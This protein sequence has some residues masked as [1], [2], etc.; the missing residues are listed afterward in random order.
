MTKFLG[1]YTGA[2]VFVLS[3]HAS[4]QTITLRA[5]LNGG[6]E[7]PTILNTGAVGTV[8][9]SVDATNREVAV[10]LKVFNLPTPATAGHIHIGSKGIGGPTVLNFPPS[11]VGRTG[12]FTMVF[13]LGDT[14][15]VFTARPAIG[16]NSIEDAIQAIVGGNAYVNVHSIQNSGGEIRGQLAIAD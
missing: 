3:T 4:A 2:L 9:V 7:T 1:L 6:E 12:D 8:E 11:L 16:I 13:R 10:T 15:G 5:N 14:P